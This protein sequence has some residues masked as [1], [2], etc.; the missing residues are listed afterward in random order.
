[1]AKQHLSVAA[2]KKIKKIVDNALLQHELKIKQ[3]RNKKKKK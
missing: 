1:M 3:K 2:L